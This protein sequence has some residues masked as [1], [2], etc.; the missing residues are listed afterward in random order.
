M[1]VDQR[2][3]EQLIA[4]VG[5]YKEAADLKCD[6][7]VLRLID[8]IPSLDPFLLREQLR[9]NGIEADSWYFAISASDQQRMHDYAALEIG[10]LTALANGNTSGRVDNSTARMVSA[11]LS[12]E[13]NEKLEPMR[14]TLNLGPEEFCEGV[15]SWRGFIYYKWSLQEFWPNLIKSLRE[16]KVITPV[17]N[18]NAAQ[19]TF[20]AESKNHIL[21]GAKASNDAIRK[22]IGIY[23]DAYASLIDRQDPKMF[24]EFLLS[25][26]SLFLEIGEKMGTLGH[27]TSFWQYRF[28]AGSPKSTDVDELTAIFEDFVRSFGQEDAEIQPGIREACISV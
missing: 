3:F 22:I 26:P 12:S 24:R 25:A 15:F 16:I 4:E 13:V 19:R 2:S 8:R 17:G 9:S 28:P 23:D 7:D 21:R 10:R 18:T 20:F 27:V 14:M 1:F 11:L 6:L 5:N